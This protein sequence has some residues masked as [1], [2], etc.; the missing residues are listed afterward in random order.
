MQRLA[1]FP[2]RNLTRWPEAN[3]V[4]ENRR[5]GRF[6]FHKVVCRPPSH[7]QHVRRTYS[8]ISPACFVTIGLLERNYSMRGFQK[9]TSHFSFSDT[10]PD[11]TVSSRAPFRMQA[12]AYPGRV[13]LSDRQ[14]YEP[15][16]APA[17]S[18]IHFDRYCAPFERP[19]LTILAPAK[20]LGHISGL[21]ADL[22]APVSGFQLSECRHAC[23]LGLSCALCVHREVKT[24]TNVCNFV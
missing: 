6:R 13:N 11:C 21:A 20:A 10:A 15:F 3:G 1:S 4:G 18:T 24:G 16:G 8:G 19:F 23:A 5:F 17:A 14:T 12:R 9:K 22:N 2:S 7:T